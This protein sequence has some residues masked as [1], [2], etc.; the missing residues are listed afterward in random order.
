VVC[1]VVFQHFGK[2]FSPLALSGL[3]LDGDFVQ[4]YA[5]LAQFKSVI[6]RAY[7]DFLQF[8]AE[9]DCFCIVLP[10]FY[11]IPGIYFPAHYS[12]RQSG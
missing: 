3:S 6:A 10:L 8:R 12:H 1:F 7:G 4:E 5:V 9:N 11:P 2:Y